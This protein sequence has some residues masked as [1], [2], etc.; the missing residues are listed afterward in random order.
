VEADLVGPQEARQMSARIDRVAVDAVLRD[1]KDFQRET[2][3]YVFRRLY[4]DEDRTRFF[5]VA[6]EVGLGK[7]L[8][9]RGVIARAIEHLWDRVGR[10]DVVYICS[11][12][13]IARQNVHRLHVDVPGQQEFALPTRVTMLPT[14]TT[15]LDDN[16]VNFVSLTPNTSFSLKTC[17][18]RREE[19]ALLYW[20]LD[21]AWDLRGTGPLNVLQG[22]AGKENFRQLVRSFKQSHRIDRH[23]AS[24]FVRELERSVAE[25]VEAG[26]RDLRT[27]FDELC[28][29]FR[30][31]RKHV[32]IEDRD[33]CSALVGD[34]RVMLA[35]VCL[36]RLEPDLIILDEFQ[37]FKHL[38]TDEN[39]AGRLAGR[40]FQYAD[41]QTE[42]RVLLL[43]ATPYKMYTLSQESE[44]DDHYH[45]FMETLR[46]LLQDSDRAKELEQILQEY[47]RELYRL[48]NH[49]GSAKR[50]LEL[51]GELEERLRRVMVRTERLAVSED[52]NGMLSQ[53]PMGSLR[54]ERRDVETYVGQMRVARRLGQG[55]VLEYWKAAPY[56]LEFMDDYALKDALKNAD[57]SKMAGVAR[58]VSDSDGLLFPWRRWASYS[59]VDPC[60]PR[61]RSLLADTVQA[62]AWR[63]LWVPPSQPYYEP[64]GPFADPASRRF[65][66]R[67]VFSSWRIVPKVIAAIVSYEA[68]RCMM[69]SFEKSPENSP[70][71]RRRRSLLLRFAR[72]GGRLAGMPVLALLYPSTV[73][74]RE[75]DPLGCAGRMLLDRDGLPRLEEVLA[76]VERRLGRLLRMMKTSDANRQAA[77]VPDEAWHWAAPILLDLEHDREH[78]RSWFER[79][80]LATTWSGGGGDE[81]DAEQSLWSE[82]VDR[83]RLLVEGRLPL[84]PQPPDL[85]RVV[86]RLALA[87]PA[88]SAL[89][90]LIRIAGGAA[91]GP[92]ARALKD[93]AAQVA[94]AFRS[95]FNLPEVTAM[96]RATDGAEPY[97]RQ[98]LDYCVNGC[99]QA[100][101]DEYAHVLYESMGLFGTSPTDAAREISRAIRSALTVRTALLGVDE[102]AA[103]PGTVKLERRRMRAR[104]ALRFSGDRTE[105][106]AGVTRASQVREAF[107]SP[108]WPFVLATTSIGQEGLDFHQY[109][110]AVVH[111]NLPSNPVDLEQREG[112]V[113][114]YKGHAVR[115]NVALRHGSEALEQTAREADARGRLPG[116]VWARLFA[117]AQ[118]DRPSGSSDL[119]PFW[120]YPVDG[121]ARI[122]RFV[123]ALPLSRDQQR[124]ADLRRS[125][126]VYRMVFGQPRQEDLLAYLLARRPRSE[127]RPLLADLRVD[128]TPRSEGPANP[129]A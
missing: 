1:L 116:D 98:V 39:E 119:V 106:G 109:C 6:D 13:I 44:T 33:D 89:R 105:E 57:D 111:W 15:D 65:T 72:R 28:R 129:P 54:L 103:G 60:N 123:P 35:M 113:H 27:R 104:F 93:G 126:A 3:D 5:L 68:E 80:D 45:D 127:L 19:R 64:A 91:T 66:K 128:L 63:L 61:V 16:R 73:L 12:A 51:K 92:A 58:V 69:C 43:S 22:S 4:T 11:N 96:V 30:Y 112:R 115:K 125:L 41:E 75:G 34:L 37:R 71:A 62:G 107:N 20:L 114:R 23:L 21:E 25:D 70:E 29:R 32:P 56:L 46:F 94:W 118:R 90:A 83:A 42:A 31:A 47:R 9:A 50:L 84:G 77:G 82:H 110:H 81:E 49:Y 26:R 76:E 120:T 85:P 102:V 38:L 67:L 99:L 2:V 53:V 55:D 97:W 88:V 121:G 52:R 108:F 117:I 95:L 10:I 78:T 36:E 8:V 24:A 48:G 74:A 87:G 122:E 40:L 124:L 101:L 7:T 14:I 100:V 86:A 17:M 79:S 18:G 59:E